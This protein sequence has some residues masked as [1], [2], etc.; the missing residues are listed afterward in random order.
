MRSL[1][2]RAK[3][4]KKGNKLAAGALRAIIRGRVQGVFFRD[5][6]ERNAHRLGLNG[7]V[8]NQADGSVEVVAEG[9]KGKLEQLLELL[10]E[11]PPAASVQGVEVSWGEPSGKFSGFAVRY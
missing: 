1:A 7:Y 9:D 3:K 6:T 4:R 11:G 8:R 2:R 10:K 5:F